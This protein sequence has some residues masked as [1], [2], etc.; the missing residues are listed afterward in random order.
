MQRLLFLGESS[1]QVSETDAEGHEIG[2]DLGEVHS[3]GAA[4]R[5]AVAGHIRTNK[6][7]RLFTD[8]DLPLRRP[9]GRQGVPPSWARAAQRQP[10]MLV[11]NLGKMPHHLPSLRHTWNST[12]GLLEL[13]SG[14]A[15]SLQIS[16]KS[17]FQARSGSTMHWIRMG[18]KNFTALVLGYCSRPCP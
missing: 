2:D 12:Q 7:Q 5:D 3:R 16:A 14:R 1:H 10:G 6:T 9:P 15:P 8:S 11:H 17:Y 13:F 18:G 4:K